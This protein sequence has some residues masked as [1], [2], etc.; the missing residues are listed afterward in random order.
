MTGVVVVDA[1]LL[2]LLVVGSASGDLL[3]GIGVR[4]IIPCMTSTYSD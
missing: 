2:A 3:E 1:N 4:G